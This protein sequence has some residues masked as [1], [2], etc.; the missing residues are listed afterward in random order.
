MNESIS[1][2]TWRKKEG[3]KEGGRKE[4]NREGKEGREEGGKIKHST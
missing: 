3:E 1:Q 2:I 4:R